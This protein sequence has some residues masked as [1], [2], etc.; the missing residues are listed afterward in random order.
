MGAISSVTYR[1]FERT[2]VYLDRPWI[3]RPG[4]QPHTFPTPKHPNYG[5]VLQPS[6]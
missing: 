6:R 5:F 1:P 4:S 3:H 2:H